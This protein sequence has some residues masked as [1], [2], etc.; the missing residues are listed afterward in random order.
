MFKNQRALEFCSCLWKV[1]WTR[2][3]PCEYTNDRTTFLVLR[4]VF[5][6]VYNYR[7]R[8]ESSPLSRIR[9]FQN[10]NIPSNHHRT[11]LYV[12][13]NRPRPLARAYVDGTLTSFDKYLITLQDKKEHIKLFDHNDKEDPDRY[14]HTIA[15][16][17]QF[18][19]K[20]IRAIDTTAVL[21]EAFTFFHPENT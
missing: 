19:F 3:H 2:R 11:R 7:F 16:V 21:L 8:F 13:C 14:K 10:F 4:R 1:N 12:A 9:Q 15:T 17:R 5:A 18:Y 6:R 20:R